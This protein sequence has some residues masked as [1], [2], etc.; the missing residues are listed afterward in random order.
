MDDLKKKGTA[1]RSKINMPEVWEVEYW[2]RE[3]GVS[4]AELQRVV[5]VANLIPLAVDRESDDD[6][7]Q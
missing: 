6:R 7:A 4:K 1:D 2:T 5:P 3:L